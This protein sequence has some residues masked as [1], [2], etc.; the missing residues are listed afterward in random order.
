MVIDTTYALNAFV[1]VLLLLASVA[2]VTTIEYLVT[3]GTQR[4][5]RKRKVMYEAWV[6]AEMLHAS[7]DHTRYVYEYVASTKHTGSEAYRGP[8]E[9]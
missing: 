8:W 3:T 5:L 7:A 2:A 4:A 9:K 1:V 6:E